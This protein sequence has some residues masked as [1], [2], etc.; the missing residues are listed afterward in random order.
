[1]CTCTYVHTAFEYRYI[2]LFTN[3]YYYNIFFEYRYILYKSIQKKT[4]LI[5]RERR[6]DYIYNKLIYWNYYTDEMTQNNNKQ[7]RLN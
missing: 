3:K 4:I 2:M 7:G 1:M 5:K 6:H